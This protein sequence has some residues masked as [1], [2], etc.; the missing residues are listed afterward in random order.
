MAV[1]DR[2]RLARSLAPFI[3]PLHRSRGAPAEIAVTW[4][5]KDSEQGLRESVPFPVSSDELAQIHEDTTRRWRRDRRIR[6]VLIL[7]SP[8]GLLAI[9]L[10]HSVFPVNSGL[11]FALGWAIMVIALIASMAAIRPR[12][13]HHLRRVL[14]QRGYEVCERCGY[15]LAALGS[16]V[17]RCPECGAKRVPIIR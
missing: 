6:W 8:L 4:M 3:R 15:A 12:Y 17:L 14:R 2:R 1:A 7:G 16:D 13:S 9:L 11:A 10:G 5:T